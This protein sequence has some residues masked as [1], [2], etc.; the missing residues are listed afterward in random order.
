MIYHSI[1]THNIVVYVVV[2]ALRTTG[3]Q[4]LREWQS[5]LA[6]SSKQQQV[7]AKNQRPSHACMRSDITFQRALACL[8]TACTTVPVLL[9]CECDRFDYYW[10]DACSSFMLTDDIMSYHTH[11]LALSFISVVVTV[12][13]IYLTEWMNVSYMY[14]IYG[15]WIFIS[16]GKQIT[17]HERPPCHMMIFP[18]Q[19]P[20]LRRRW[21]QLLHY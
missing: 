11:I 19:A 5:R 10:R 17:C 6:K 20:N 2:H 1:D 8:V 15:S 18:P 7:C 16:M 14:V 9:L 21:M 3:R 13:K 12:S 4:Y